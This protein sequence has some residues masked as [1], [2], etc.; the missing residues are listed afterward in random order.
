M[1]TILERFRRGFVGVGGIANGRGGEWSVQSF[2]ASTMVNGGPGAG[3]AVG[4]RARQRH[5]YI[6]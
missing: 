5:R 4:R 1:A 3:D 2:T 6:R